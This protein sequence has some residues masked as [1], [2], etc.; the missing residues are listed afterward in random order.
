MNQLTRLTGN[1]LITEVARYRPIFRQVVRRPYDVINSINFGEFTGFEINPTFYVAGLKDSAYLYLYYCCYHYRDWSELPDIIKGFDE[2]RHDFEG[3]GLFIPVDGKKGV[4]LFT[5]YH[6]EI[7]RYTIHKRPDE[8]KDNPIIVSI[9]HAG[10]GIRRAEH[11]LENTI[12]YLPK[13][14]EEMVLDGTDQNWNKI[15]A[16]FKEHSVTL[17]DEWN[18]QR[19]KRKFNRRIVDKLFYNHPDRF[20]RYS[21][22]LSAS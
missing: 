4:T 14:F 3:V 12:S 15:R 11:L 22:R 8:L 16:Y 13:V 18:D 20:L 6:Y 2:H 5:R 17:P 1:E 10:H 7:R 9:D 21:N 19:M